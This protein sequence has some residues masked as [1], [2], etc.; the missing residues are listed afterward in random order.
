MRGAAGTISK[1]FRKISGKHSGKVRH[2]RITEN[3]YCTG[4][5]AHTSARTDVEIQDI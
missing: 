1:S 4:N 5:C 3:N 2:Q